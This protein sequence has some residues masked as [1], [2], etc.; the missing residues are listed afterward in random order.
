MQ[1]FF[2]CMLKLMRYDLIMFKYSELENNIYKY[3]YRIY[4]HNNMYAFSIFV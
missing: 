1:T 2:L 3:I 4:N